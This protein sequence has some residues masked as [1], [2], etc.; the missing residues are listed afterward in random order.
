M[1]SRILALTSFF[2]VLGCASVVQLEELGSQFESDWQGVET[3]PTILVVGYAYDP[4]KRLDFE[5]SMVGA[6]RSIGISAEASAGRMPDLRSING[7]LLADYLTD[8]KNSALLL[9]RALSVTTRQSRKVETAS[10][11]G[12]FE[13]TTIRW[14]VETGAQ[15]EASLYVQDFEG[16]VWTQW[17]QIRAGESIGAEALDAYVEALLESMIREGVVDRLR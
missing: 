13:D 10:M 15:L 17:S 12:L 7:A 11:G 9:A 1:F 3:S 16:A 4:E 5:Q 6:L 2:F 14:D 8:S